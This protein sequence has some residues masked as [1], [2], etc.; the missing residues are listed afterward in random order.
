MKLTT[1][2]PLLGGLAAGYVLGAAAGR[3]RYHQIRSA[4]NRLISHPR[5][6][7]VVFDLA[8]RAKA[9][10]HRLP[11]PAARLIAKSATRLEDRL[12]RPVD[13]AD[14]ATAGD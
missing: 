6:Q 4:A 5:S 13:A 7:Q 3:R 10:S 14:R 2:V 11:G 1:K 9:S 12:T 8:D